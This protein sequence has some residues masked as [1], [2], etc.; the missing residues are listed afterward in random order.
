[1]HVG[2]RFRKFTGM[3]RELF[4]LQNPWIL[5]YN[6]LYLGILSWRGMHGICL[7]MSLWLQKAARHSS[8]RIQRRPLFIP[9]DATRSFSRNSEFAIVR[10]NASQTATSSLHRPIPL[11]SIRQAAINQAFV[12]LHQLDPYPCA[13]TGSVERKR[14]F[15]DRRCVAV[16]IVCR[17]LALEWPW[18]VGALVPSLNK[19]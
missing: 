10:R 14:S 12:R 15:L 16:A 11:S 18:F 9:R 17:A 7:L 2:T 4:S 5:P 8:C 13:V 19:W 6:I 3:H 1:M